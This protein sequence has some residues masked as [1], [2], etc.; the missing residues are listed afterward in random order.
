MFEINYFQFIC[1]LWAALGIG[2]RIVMLVMGEK[3]AK[4]EVSSAYTQNKPKWIYPVGVIGYFLV[5]LTWYQF[6]VTDI[7]YSWMVAVL[8]T[9]TTI[10]ITVLLFNYKAFHN[11][12][13]SMLK[14]KKKMLQLNIGVV[15]L[16]CV[17]VLM[18]VFLY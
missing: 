8:I 2:S 1:F 17:L 9:V 5:I 18:G 14:D 15:L 16:S 11:F 4:W 12:L 13:V 3:W 7:K 6:F 10:K